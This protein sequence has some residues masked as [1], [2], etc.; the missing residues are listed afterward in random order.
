METPS[1]RGWRVD[2]VLL[3][4]R[5]P[6]HEEGGLPEAV[7]L[8]PS[9]RGQDERKAGIQVGQKLVPPVGDV[10]IAGEHDT[11]TVAGVRLEKRDVFRAVA[12]HLR[13]VDD[14][15][16]AHERSKGLDAGSADVL[17]EGELHAASASSNFTA[18]RTTSGGTPK[19]S[20]T[21]RSFFSARK[22]RSRASV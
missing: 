2:R 19:S 4:F 8:I 5:P 13:Q 21:A 9:S 14:L 20:A 22:A 1:G 11:A 12:V 3:N 17:V 18:S 10:G 15:D 6:T 16:L 7:R